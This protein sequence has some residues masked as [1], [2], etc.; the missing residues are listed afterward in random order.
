VHELESNYNGKEREGAAAVAT[1]ILQR[2]NNEPWNNS[3]A[4]G[5]KTRMNYSLR[6]PQTAVLF[7]QR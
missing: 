7:K 1:K 5:G 6:D 2:N 4:G 3:G